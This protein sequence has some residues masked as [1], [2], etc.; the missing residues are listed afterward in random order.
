MTNAPSIKIQ[1]LCSQSILAWIWL[2]HLQYF[3][4]LMIPRSPAAS[5]LLFL[6][7]YWDLLLISMPLTTFAT[8]AI[9]ALSTFFTNGPC[10]SLLFNCCYHIFY[11]NYIYMTYVMLSNLQVILF[12]VY[13]I[14]KNFEKIFMRRLTISYI[15][16]YCNIIILNTLN[17][18]VYY[19]E[20]TVVK[21]WL[22]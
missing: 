19:I 17:K 20:I 12:F 6:I 16:I 4:I 5:I 13:F 21:G 3:L 1:F 22:T 8:S 9:I 15:I 2:T 11:Y 18:V 14:I 10:I 7:A